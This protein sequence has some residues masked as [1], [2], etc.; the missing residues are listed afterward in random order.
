MARMPVKDILRQ[1]CYAFFTGLDEQGEAAW[2]RFADRAPHLGIYE[3][4]RPWGP[5]R[6]VFFEAGWGAPETR[7]SPRI[8]A[9]WISADGRTFSLAYSC[10]PVGPYRLN[11]H[12]CRVTTD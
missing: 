7:F 11:L 5:W 10:I 6:T 8:P 1:E 12:T 2:G 3:A 9:K 4:P